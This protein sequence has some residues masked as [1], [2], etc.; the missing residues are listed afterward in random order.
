MTIF[1]NV[2][3]MLASASYRVTTNSAPSGAYSLARSKWGLS[4]GKI[5]QRRIA[6]VLLLRTIIVLLGRSMSAHRWI[7]VSC[8]RIPAYR[9]KASMILQS[10]HCAWQMHASI[11]SAGTMTRRSSLP[12]TVDASP[13]KGLRVIN[14]FLTA[15]PKN[16]LHR[17]IVRRTVF[18]ASPA[19]YFFRSL[20]LVWSPWG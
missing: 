13:S 3:R 12:V 2:V 4:S 16:C 8:D 9:A 1:S 14:S 5:G 19:L 10:S 15:D 17:P 11:Q 6:G 20:P 7:R 18:S